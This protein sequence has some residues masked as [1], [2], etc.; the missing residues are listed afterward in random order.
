MGLAHMYFVATDSAERGISWHMGDDG[1][2]FWPMM[3]FG[4]VIMVLFTSA[5]VLAIVWLW[6]QIN[7]K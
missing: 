2:W 7:K 1:T 3:L 6:K 4:W 5:L